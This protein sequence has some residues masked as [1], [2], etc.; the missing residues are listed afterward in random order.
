MNAMEQ[1]IAHLNAIPTDQYDRDRAHQNISQGDEC[2]DLNEYMKAQ[3]KE[4]MEA[5]NISEEEMLRLDKELLALY[6]RK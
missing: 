1:L 4:Y 2:A 5:N 6:K 3:E